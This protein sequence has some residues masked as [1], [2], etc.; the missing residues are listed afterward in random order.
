MHTELYDPAPGCVYNTPSLVA[1]LSD[2]LYTR[3]SNIHVHPKPT[4]QPLNSNLIWGWLQSG[5]VRPCVVVRGVRKPPNA[6]TQEGPRVGP[7]AIFR[8]LLLQGK[9]E[10][11]PGTSVG[12]RKRMSVMCIPTPAGPLVE[13][14]SQ[15]APGIAVV[16]GATSV[17][18]TMREEDR[19]SP[20]RAHVPT[21][22]MCMRCALTYMHPFNH[23]LH[24]SHG[25]SKVTPTTRVLRFRPAS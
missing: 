15:R 10:H 4:A 1:N 13:R 25:K 22:P 21:T 3:N 12:L 23:L 18:F 24:T 9:Q 8:T 17:S 5:E 19:V 7:W 20:S 11:S 2:S 16:Q 6:H 14:L